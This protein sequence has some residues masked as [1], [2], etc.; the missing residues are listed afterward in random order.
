MPH[1]LRVGPLFDTDTQRTGDVIKVLE[2]EKVL[3][4]GD[5]SGLVHT[6]EGVGFG[7]L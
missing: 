4:A 2:H 3:R 1:Y 5:E 7:V 6:A